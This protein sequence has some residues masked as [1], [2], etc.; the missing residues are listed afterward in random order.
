[1]LG[2]RVGPRSRFA[3]LGAVACVTL[4]PGA[5]PAIAQASTIKPVQGLVITTADF[6]GLVGTDVNYDV[7]DMENHLKVMSVT[8]EVTTFELHLGAPTNQV[9]N[10]KIGRFTI[11]RDVRRVDLDSALRLSLFWSS[12]D[13]RLLP[14]QTFGELSSAGLKTLDSTG[15]L[16]L[17]LGTSTIDKTMGAFAS[18]LGSAPSPAEPKGQSGAAVTP[19][20]LSSM[21]ALLGYQRRYYRGTLHR[22]EPGTVPFPVL[23]D[24]LRTTLPA[25]HAAGDFRFGTEPTE[26]VEFW[27]LDDP[28]FPLTLKWTH[29]DRYSVVIRIDRPS[30]TADEAARL[31]TDLAGKSCRV[32]LHGVYFATG[33]AEIMPESAPALKAVAALIKAHPDW[34]LTVEGHTD[35]IGSAAYNQDLSERRAR[36]VR[37]AL[38]SQYDVAAATLSSKG[39]GFTRPVESNATIEG[40]AHNRRVELSRD[41]A[42]EGGAGRNGGA[43]SIPGFP[44]EAHHGDSP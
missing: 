41:C 21:F 32:E 2:R 5:A 9:A 33:S 15:Q 38:V 20:N 39:Y 12:D 6:Y 28:A 3:T 34:K 1:M 30:S 35:S 42:A 16:P 11:T 44:Q 27:W 8:P 26:H 31:G 10:D 25:V 43:R 7:L 23:L 22:V 40:R 19:R 13:P 36:A 4:A 29:Q 18:A 17:V 14:G 24:G 37:T